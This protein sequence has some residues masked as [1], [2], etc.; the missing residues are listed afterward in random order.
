MLRPSARSE[1][2]A[3]CR[4]RR[5]WCSVAARLA[6]TASSTIATIAANTSRIASTPMVVRGCAGSRVPEFAGS[7]VR[8]PVPMHWRTRE[9]GNPRTGERP[10]A[11]KIRIVAVSH[12]P[13][14]LAQ[15]Y[16]VCEAV[17]RA[18]Y[19]NFPVATRLLPRAM[20]PH[21]AAVYA[22][23]RVADDVADGGAAA[24]AVRQAH[25]AQW[26]DR[27][28]RAVEKRGDP[29]NETTRDELIFLALGHSIRTLDLPLPLFDDLLNAFGQDT[30][31]K[32]YA[33]WSD[34]LDYC[35]R[36]ANPIGRLVLRI[37]AY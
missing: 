10:H 5:Y 33:S 31:T 26:Q 15:A 1:S 19:E 34:L 2:R 37:A 24:A 18:H 36:S 6:A 11:T 28:H 12:R 25:L 27:L 3:R 29:D 20:R 13:E 32:R 14:P 8:N 16:A 21:I 22:F 4:R 35:R 7:R 9:P 17:A 30:M 23:A